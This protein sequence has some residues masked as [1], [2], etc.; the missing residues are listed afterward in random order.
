M[1]EK[2]KPNPLEYCFSYGVV[3][4]WFW[5]HMGT[6][7]LMISTVSLTSSA[8]ESQSTHKFQQISRRFFFFKEKSLM[9]VLPEE[10]ILMVSQ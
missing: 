7:F 4:V 6:V 9:G 2:T 5:M 1:Q 3:V 10:L 8:V